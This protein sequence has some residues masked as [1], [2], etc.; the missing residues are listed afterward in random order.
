[1][2]SILIK[3]MKPKKRIS[4]PSLLTLCKRDSFEDVDR[5]CQD[6]NKEMNSLGFNDQM[7]ST[8]RSIQEINAS[9]DEC[10]NQIF[11]KDFSHKVIPVKLNADGNCLPGTGSMHVYGNDK[12]ATEMRV[13]IILEATL[14][15]QSYPSHKYL[16]R[17][18]ETTCRNLLKIYAMYSDE[19][20]PGERLTEK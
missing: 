6:I 15:R 8:E 4:L 19:Y 1:M 7:N 16:Q 11:P 20:T 9:V 18:H 3:L 10:S 14:N 13:K 2:M 12:H 17:G 5:A